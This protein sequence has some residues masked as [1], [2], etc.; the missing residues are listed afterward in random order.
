MLSKQEFAELLALPPDERMQ[1][2]MDL[3]DSVVDEDA[4]LAELSP[5]QI[6]ELESRLADEQIHPHDEMTWEAVKSSLRA[7]RA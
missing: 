6:R 4:S 1:L 3:W 5:L 2:A 7:Q